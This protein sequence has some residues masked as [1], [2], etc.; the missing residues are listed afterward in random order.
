[1]PY[2][3]YIGIKKIPKMSI[4]LPRDNIFFQ[5]LP[6]NGRILLLGFDYAIDGTE[7]I[8]FKQGTNLHDISAVRLRNQTECAIVVLGR[9]HTE[10]TQTL[11]VIYA[12]IKHD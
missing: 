1:M 12:R 2:R 5:F 9:Q 7:Y 11:L 3:L 10:Q 8:L 6:Y 4:K